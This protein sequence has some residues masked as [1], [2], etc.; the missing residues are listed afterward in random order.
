MHRKFSPH[1]VFTWS[2]FIIS[3]I[4]EHM[5]MITISFGNM[6]IHKHTSSCRCGLRI[7]ARQTSNIYDSNGGR[8]RS[9]H[10]VDVIFIYYGQY[11]VAHRNHFQI[12]SNTYISIEITNW[13]CGLRIDCSGRSKI[14][15][16]NGCHARSAFY[17]SIF[18]MDPKPDAD[19][20]FTWS[21]LV[22]SITVDEMVRM[23]I[24]LG[25]RISVDRVPLG[26][27]GDTDRIWPFPCTETTIPIGGRHDLD[28]C[29]YY[30]SRHHNAYEI[31]SNAYIRTDIAT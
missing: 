31:I 10:H 27:I 29:M 4:V 12:I 11:W 17:P 13:R 21:L 19:S 28:C 16:P 30:S 20:V 5:V 24:W 23:T 9:P 6:Y 14:H 26:N 15:D 22:V 18:R 3:M 7:N 8:A 1:H 2:P 25:T